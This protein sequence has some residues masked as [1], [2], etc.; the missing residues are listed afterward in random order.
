MTRDMWCCLMIDGGEDHGIVKSHGHG[1]AIL[2]DA[3]DHLV[4]GEERCAGVGDADLLAHDFDFGCV[5]KIL[6]SL[7]GRLANG[8]NFVFHYTFELVLSV[9]A[10]GACHHECGCGEDKKFL[11]YCNNYWFLNRYYCVFTQ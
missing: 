4:E 5:A 11:H 8:G 6:E 7:I 9:E 10:H 3:V 1:T 2:T